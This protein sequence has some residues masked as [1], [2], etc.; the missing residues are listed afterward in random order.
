VRSRLVAPLLAATVAVAACSG[1]SERDLPKPSKDFCTAAHRYEER[2]QSKRPPSVDEQIGMVERLAAAAPAD[3][4]ADAE[5]FLDA[6]RRVR[7]DASVKDNPKVQAAVDNVN[8]RAGNGCG[9]FK[10]EPGSG[11]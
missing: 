4:K 5:T 10:R 1:T 6:I 8:R 11:M 9:F 2:I 3:V 7:T